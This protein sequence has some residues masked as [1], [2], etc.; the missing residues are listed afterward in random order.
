MKKLLLLVFC[1]LII[2]VFPSCRRTGVKNGAELLKFS[3]ESVK[4]IEISTLPFAESY[5]RTVSDPKEISEIISYINGRELS[6]E[7]SENPDEMA[8]MT[9]ISEFCFSDGSDIKLY[10]F[11]DFL[12]LEGGDW[13]EIADGERLSEMLIN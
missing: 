6:E 8:G 4:K 3:C 1:L 2:A 11:G 13:L 12:R 5:K 10:A 7:L 9:V